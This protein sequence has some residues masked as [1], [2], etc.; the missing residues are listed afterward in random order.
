MPCGL[1]AAEGGRHS[2]PMPGWRA[3]GPCVEDPWAERSYG[4]Q[5]R[6]RGDR[7]R[8]PP[9]SLCSE[10]HHRTPVRAHPTL[11]HTLESVTK[12]SLGTQCPAPEALGGR[13]IRVHFGGCMLGGTHAQEGHTRVAPHALP[14]QSGDTAGPYATTSLARITHETSPSPALAIHELPSIPKHSKSNEFIQ[15]R[16]LHQS[17]KMSTPSCSSRP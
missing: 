16:P 9:Q 8:E 2:V 5:G 12:V 17:K 15:K 14:Q 11:L 7:A 1:G 6:G 13:V 3:Q 10:V 4:C